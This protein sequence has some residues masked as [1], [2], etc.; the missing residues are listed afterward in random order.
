MDNLYLDRWLSDF[1]TLKGTLS[2]EQ[3][4]VLNRLNPADYKDKNLTSDWEVIY[5]IND[6]MSFAAKWIEL[7]P[8]LAS[9]P[10]DD[11]KILDHIVYDQFK[12]TEDDLRNLIKCRKDELAADEHEKKVQERAEFFR[13]HKEEIDREIREQNRNTKL[14]RLFMFI[15][16]ALA[17][18]A[19]V[20]IIQKD[21]PRILLFSGL[22]ILLGVAPIVGLIIN[23]HHLKKNTIIPKPIDPIKGNM[24]IAFIGSIVFLYISF[25]GE[26]IILGS[27]LTYYLYGW[28]HTLG[29]VYT[30]AIVTGISFLIFIII[31]LVSNSKE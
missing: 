14:S 15:T 10:E 19:T 25:I 24:D 18:T 28:Y 1:P 8:N 21:L 12:K 27:P 31:T 6:H 17:S 9:L 11:Y 4:E 16:F 29:Q 2:L 22:T 5:L 3:Q 7:Y 20:C 13:Q 26:G 23:L 30:G